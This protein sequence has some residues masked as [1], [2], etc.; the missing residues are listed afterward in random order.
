MLSRDNRMQSATLCE[1]WKGQF[2]KSS[3]SLL[4][5]LVDGLAVLV[6]LLVD[7]SIDVYNL[8]LRKCT[9]LSILYFIL[10]MGQTRPLFVYFR[11]F[12][13][14]MTNIAQI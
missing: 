6:V 1:V 12:H 13:N 14:T 8:S 5:S 10:K 3:S 4:F 7:T 2:W 9:W 11:S